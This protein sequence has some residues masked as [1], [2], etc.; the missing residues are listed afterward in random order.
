MKEAVGTSLVFGIIM[1]FIGIL[2]AILVGSISFSKGFKIRNRII[3]RIEEYQGFDVNT[4]SIIEEDLKSIG[5]KIVDNVDCKDR[6]GGELLTQQYNDYNYC[7]YRYSTT[8]G[9][10]YGVT[11]F[12]QFDVPLIGQ[13]IKIPVYGETRVIYEK[14]Q[15]RN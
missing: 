2:I 1:L 14:D 5:Y 13:Y 10:Y 6:D 12:I 11:V 8:R 15:V 9:N 3:D 4:H 7:V